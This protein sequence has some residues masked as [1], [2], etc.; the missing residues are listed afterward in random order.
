MDKIIVTV[1]LIIGG[2]VASFAIFN[3]V[4]P[5][6]ERGSQAVSD[7]VGVVSDRITSR[8][9]TIQ[10]GVTDSTVDFWVKNTGSSRI[11]AIQNSDIFFGVHGETARIP[12]GDSDSPLPYWSYQLEGGYTQW[13]QAVTNKITIHLSESLT[14]DF[15]VFKIV[16]PNGIFDQMSFSWE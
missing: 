10:V 12:F 6:V 4:Y 1:M 16:L 15:Y 13:G 2:I 11:G 5:A 14:P 7:S 8:V 3:G 9:D